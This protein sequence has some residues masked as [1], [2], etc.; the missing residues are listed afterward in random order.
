MRRRFFGSGASE[1]PRFRRRGGSPGRL[2]ADPSTLLRRRS[3]IPD[4]SEVLCL[5]RVLSHPQT[6][7]GRRFL[8]PLLVGLRR[9]QSLHTL[10]KT[11]RVI[12]ASLF[13]GSST[14]IPTEVSLAKDILRPFGSRRFLGQRVSSDATRGKDAAIPQHHCP[15][16][17]GRWMRRSLAPENGKRMV[18]LFFWGLAWPAPEIELHHLP[19]PAP[20][21]LARPPGC[22]R[23]EWVHQSCAQ[24]R[25]SSTFSLARRS[26]CTLPPPLLLTR[27]RVSRP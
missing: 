19:L 22:R 2:V 13:L 16:P 10:S 20:L 21:V 9:C 15:V 6:W 7:E 27:G 5:R 12:N 4:A 18:D 1:V 24:P 3:L 23:K 11:S 25:C 8:L 14:R 26:S 17:R